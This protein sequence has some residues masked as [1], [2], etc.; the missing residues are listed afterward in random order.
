MTLHSAVRL[1]LWAASVVI[2]QSLAGNPLRWT[3]V[4][5][6][7]IAAVAAPRRA[8]RLMF[9]ARWLILALLTVFAWSTPGRLLWP[10][11][12]WASPSA[13]GLALAADHCARLAGLLIL[14]ALLLQHTTRE[15]LVGGLYTLLKPLLA[16]GLD[17]T[18]LALRL[19]LVLRYS[20]ATLPRGQWRDWLRSG[21]DPAATDSICLKLHPLRTAD[22][23]AM[24]VAATICLCVWFR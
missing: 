19:D 9:R 14:V 3:V 10:E 20:D 24:V 11:A 8:V 4:A 16:L 12:D 18:R 5:L 17:R 1:L 15:S 13:E 21:P 2:L 7:L 22:M 23:I 6:A